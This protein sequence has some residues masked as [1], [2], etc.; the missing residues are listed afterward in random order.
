MRG[1]DGLACA[2]NDGTKEL[3]MSFAG[4]SL[5]PSPEVATSGDHGQG[6]EYGKHGGEPS[7]ER[8]PVYV[9]ETKPIVGLIKGNIVGLVVDVVVDAEVGL[10]LEDDGGSRGG[11]RS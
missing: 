2:R 3:R 11:G 9:D 7:R 6:Q 5:A 1:S 10:I 8:C 4:L